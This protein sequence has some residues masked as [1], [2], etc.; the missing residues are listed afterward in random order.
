VYTLDFVNAGTQDAAGVAITET[1]PDNT[2]F[3]ATES[4]AGWSCADG[5]PAR[6]PC[7][8]TVGALEVNASGS[9]TFAVDVITPLPA[10][11]TAIVNTAS[12]DDGSD[13]PDTDPEDDSDETITP[14]RPTPVLLVTKLDALTTDADGSRDVTA[15]DTLTYTMEIRNTGDVTLHDVVFVDAPDPNT[16]LL[17]GHVTTSQ[18]MVT[19][20]NATGHST[21]S[22]DVGDLPGGATALLSFAVVINPSL[23]PNVTQVANQGLATTA[24]LPG[25]LSDD[26]ETRAASDP[27]RTPLGTAPLIEAI[28]NDQLEQDADISGSVTRGDTLLYFVTLRNIGLAPATDVVF[29]DPPDLG[30]TLIAGSVITTAGMV[31]QGN[32]DGDTAVAVDV[33]T[34]E[35]GVSV[36]ISYM[37]KINPRLPAGLTALQNQGLVTWEDSE[38]ESASEPTDDPSTLTDDDATTTPLEG[39]K[40]L[41]AAK[42]DILLDD[43]NGDGRAGPGDTVRYVVALRNTGADRATGV[44]FTDT[45]D[46][47]S[48]LVEDSVVTT[49]GTVISGNAPGDSMMEV[50]VG[51][52]EAGAIS[53]LRFDVTV[54]DPLLGGISQLQNQGTLVGCSGAGAHPD[55]VAPTLR[56]GGQ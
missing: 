5:S 19:R 38:G 43:D 44:R 11:A 18:G 22:V 6:T 1:V 31:T 35:A 10:E 50:E 25:V 29:T 46:A 42:L 4:A 16:T 40:G 28:K 26:P 14:V 27:T 53:T 20:G 23:P 32:S 37:V 13:E 21:V 9:A 34:V 24:E 49:T 17:V 3:N 45:P 7:T 15:G 52:L 33:G 41:A 51:T 39:S 54:N 30:T 8:L 12:I 56:H 55:R 36:T 48:T 2:T 47:H